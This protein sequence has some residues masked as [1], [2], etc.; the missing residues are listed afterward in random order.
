MVLVSRSQPLIIPAHHVGAVVPLSPC[1]PSFLSQT[2]SISLILALMH[3]WRI[4]PAGH[5][6]SAADGYTPG[7][8]PGY[9]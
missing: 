5:V 9:G 8:V 2:G 7:Q 6:Q 3:P 4:R 1:L